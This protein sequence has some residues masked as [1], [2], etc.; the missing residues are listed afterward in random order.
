MFR[1]ATTKLLS[2]RIN[3]THLY[4][5]EEL[6]CNEVILSGIVKCYDI[7]WRSDDISAK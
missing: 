4:R 3:Q 5:K 7:Q 1:L 2:V 6:R